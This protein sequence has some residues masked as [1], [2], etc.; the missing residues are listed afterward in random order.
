MGRNWRLKVPKICHLYWGGGVLPYLRFMT[1]KSFMTLNPEWEVWLWSSVKYSA[2][3]SWK[4][5]EQ[6][7]VPQ[8]AD[9]TEQLYSLSV[10]KKTVDFQNFGFSNGISEVHKA[11]F[12]RSYIMSVYGGVWVDMDVLF[13]KPIT[14]IEVNELTN[15]DIE[16]FVCMCSYGHSTG[17]L[18]S[19]K[20]S[21]FFERLVTMAHREFNPTLYQCLGP[22]IYNK[23]GGTIEEINKTSSALNMKMDVVYAH[24]A[25]H[26]MEIL[27][28]VHP[29]FTEGSIGV[30]WY[31]GHPMWEFF[32]NETDGGLKNLPD[33]IIGNLLKKYGE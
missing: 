24:D 15:K 4:T 11:D 31:A 29:R 13:F 16:I 23:Y 22:E 30:H 27:Q 20:G 8:C 12:M 32:F 33:N 26:M 3:E 17:F 28:N 10:V 14:D 19:Q 6:K 5:V 7:Y 9:F 25:H 1:V 18:M 21:R 2:G